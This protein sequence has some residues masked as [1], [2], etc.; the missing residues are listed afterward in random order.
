MATTVVSLLNHVA[1]PVKDH[2][3][4]AVVDWVAFTVKLGRASHGGHL[5]RSLESFGVSRVIPLDAGAGG[6]A[7]KF[8]IELQHPDRY[9]VVSKV[10]SRLQSDYGLS[11]VPVATGME[12]S[13]DFCPKTPDAMGAGTRNITERLMRSIAPPEINNPRLANDTESIV[14]PDRRAKIDPEMTL[15]VGNNG[16]D[17]LWRVYWKR[18]DD[19]FIGDEG[20]RQPKPLVEAEWRARAEVRL[21][22]NALIALG[23]THP[24]DL[25]GFRFERLH[26]A[27]Y[28]KFCKKAEGVPV[29]ASSVLVRAMAESL[30]ID[31]NAPACVL[32]AFAQRDRRRRDRKLS[33]YLETDTELTEAVR[34]ALRGLTRRF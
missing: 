4:R 25:E 29:L 19:T 7:A 3:A 2:T 9:A 17:L 34:N 6:A 20:K 14:V 1:V 24:A 15:Y 16:D 21:Q 33:R 30:G 23:I 12:V 32:A 27:G 26:T 11:V 31:E 10:I 22:G 5:K 28:F 13:I 18:T 8:R